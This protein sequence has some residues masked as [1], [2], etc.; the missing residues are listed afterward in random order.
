MSNPKD[1]TGLILVGGK[2]RRMGFN[3]ALIELTPSGPTVIQTVADKLKDVCPEVILVGSQLE[4]Y[5]FLNL[6]QV[7]D[8]FPNTGSL[9]GIYSGLKSARTDYALVVACD[10]PFLNTELLKYMISLPRDYDVLIPVLDEPEPMHAIYSKRCIPWIAQSIESGS[11]RII[12]W[13]DRAKVK[14]IPKETIARFDSDFMSF[15]NMNTPEELEFAKSY[16]NRK[17]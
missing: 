12:G 14:Y 4:P 10:M 17:I 15:F 5:R 6:P 16:M 1:I 2:S 9:G 8:E 13:F 3:K 7:P 11:Y